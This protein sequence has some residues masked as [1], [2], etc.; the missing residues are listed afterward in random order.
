MLKELNKQS[1]L[2][3]KQVFQTRQEDMNMKALL[4]ESKK[5][6]FLSV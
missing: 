5:A 4:L 2:K 1:Q 3:L 6:H